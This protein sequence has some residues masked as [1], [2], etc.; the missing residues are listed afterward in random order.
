MLNLLFN[1]PLLAAGYFGA[2]GLDRLLGGELALS[3][4]ISCAVGVAV[5]R[6]GRRPPRAVPLTNPCNS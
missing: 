6:R 1:A 5:R 2:M 3:L 4:V